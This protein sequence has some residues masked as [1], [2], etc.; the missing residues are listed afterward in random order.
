MQ[1]DALLDR[2]AAF[3]PTRY[4]FISLYLDTRPDQHGRERFG[5]FVRKELPG[6]A[7]TYAERTPERES[8]DRDAARI[9]QYLET[10]ARPS[11]HGMAIFACAGAGEFFEA[12]QL[13]V[14]VD[15]SE[16]V[17]AAHPYVYPLARLND[18]Y[19]RYAA[20]LADSYT[21][22]IFVFGLG[23]LEASGDVTGT[24]VRRTSTGG[25]SQARYQRHV[26]HFHV[27]H[28]KELVEALDRVVRAENI[29][30]V[31]LAGDEAVIPLLR[32]QL[33]KPLQD[34][35]VDI[36]RMEVSARERE[37]FEASL[38]A[39][40][41][42]DARDDAD[43]VRRAVD[44]YRGG[45]LGVVGLAETQR[46]LDNGQVHELLLSARPDALEDGSGRPAAEVADELVTKAR[47]TSAQVTFVDDPA[48]LA[49]VG[50]VAALLR[51]RI[52][53][54]AA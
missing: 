11:T 24:K 8:F 39:L 33:P 38:A 4:P 5:A 37:V 47:Q 44:A 41:E 30:H 31:V 53:G 18:R 28:V 32:E 6:R 40:R 36:L 49:E 48:L 17:V 1:V 21:A 46:A 54:R 50:G 3:E 29:P 52:Q 7:R 13:E 15:E 26:E 22:R 34:R 25:W 19:R 43:K 14:P 27:Q 20:V 42:R 2:L 12:I 9:Q 23:E 10:E 45:G 16:L 51:Y 35:L